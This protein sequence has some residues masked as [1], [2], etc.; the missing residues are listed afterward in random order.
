M[1]DIS[2][3][4]KTQSQKGYGLL[5]ERQ[6]METIDE[7]LPKRLALY[8]LSDGTEHQ[9]NSDNSE[10]VRYPNGNKE[11][12]LPDGRIVYFDA[13]QRTSVTCTGPRIFH[14][15]K[16]RMKFV[17]SCLIRTIRGY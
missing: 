16:T 2:R 1:E 11:F 15:V 17:Q 13:K 12:R 9:F 8:E 10:V 4:S 14:P 3:T 7:K 5:R 6:A